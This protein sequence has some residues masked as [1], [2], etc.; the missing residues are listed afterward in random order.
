M[1]RIRV[2]TTV[3]S[4]LLTAARRIRVGVND[5]KLLD[6]ALAALAAR[7]RASE[8]DASYQAYADHPIEEPDD[9]GDLSSFRDAAARS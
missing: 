3:D 8:R 5:A 2:S 4:D 7:H 9:W 6:E 1:A